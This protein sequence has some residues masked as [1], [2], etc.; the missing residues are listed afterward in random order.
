VTG[1]G[2]FINVLAIKAYVL[3]KI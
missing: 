2:M 3:S 1:H